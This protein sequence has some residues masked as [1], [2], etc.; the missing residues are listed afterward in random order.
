LQRNYIGRTTVVGSEGQ[1]S[2]AKK[3]GHATSTEMF[4]ASPLLQRKCPKTNL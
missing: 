2:R 3:A 1:S 4:R